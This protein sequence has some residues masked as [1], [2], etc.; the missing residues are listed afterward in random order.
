MPDPLQKTTKSKS[1]AAAPVNLRTNHKGRY[2]QKAGEFSDEQ[3]G[4]GQTGRKKKKK[5][6]EAIHQASSREFNQKSSL[7]QSSKST[8]NK[9]S[10]SK[11]Q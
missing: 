11:H 8:E 4:G 1:C 7:G 9:V 3:L 5:K 10:N 2:K 6:G